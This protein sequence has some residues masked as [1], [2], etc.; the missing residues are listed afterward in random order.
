VTTLDPGA[1][2]D[3]FARSDA[4]YLLGALA[5]EERAAYASHLRDCPQC[6]ESVAV[7]AG[8]PGL[9]GRVPAEMAESLDPLAGD[10]GPRAP[11]PVPPD[12]LRAGLLRRVQRDRRRRLALVGGAV[13][14]AA[15]AGAVGFAVVTGPVDVPRPAPAA[16]AS[17]SPLAPVATTPIRAAASMQEVAWG[18]RIQLSCRYDGAAPYGAGTTDYAL[19]VTDRTGHSEQVATWR[20]VPGRT[21]TVVAATAMRRGDIATVEVRTSSGEPVLRLIT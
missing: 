1:A 8:L 21:S 6:A 15:A 2:G 20:A 3:R 13:I 16:V 10:G 12:S 19:V 14:V 4:A 18:T 11:H 7:L 9:L 17:P 5:P